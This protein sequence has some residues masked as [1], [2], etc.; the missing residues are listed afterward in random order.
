MNCVLQSN[1][2]REKIYIC[3]EYNS[4]RFYQIVFRTNANNTYAK[5]SEQNYTLHSKMPPQKISLATEVSFSSHF[6]ISISQTT[7]SIDDK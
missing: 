6:F 4:S 5:D 2:Q 1:F 7:N 3:D